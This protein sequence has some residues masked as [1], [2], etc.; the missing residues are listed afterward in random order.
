MAERL[1]KRVTR[2]TGD[3]LWFAIHKK[4]KALDRLGRGGDGDTLW[5]I[6]FAEILNYVEWDSLRV[7]HGSKVWVLHARWLFS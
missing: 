7:H 1:R 4:D 6:S 3:G 5:N 2:K